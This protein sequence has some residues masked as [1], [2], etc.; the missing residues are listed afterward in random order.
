[1]TCGN[2]ELNGYGRIPEPGSMS[3]IL[4]G[5][6]SLAGLAVSRKRK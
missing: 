3:M 1:M 6:L 2:D 5:L 4:V